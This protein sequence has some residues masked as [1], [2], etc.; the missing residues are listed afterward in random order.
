MR[1]ILFWIL[2][3]PVVTSCS[4]PL[5]P[6]FREIRNLSLRQLPLGTKQA[7]LAAE[8]VLYNPNSFGVEIKES[9]LDIFLADQY[10]GKA[11]QTLKIQVPAKKTFSLPVSLKILPGMLLKNGLKLLTDDQV[12]VWAKGTVYIGKAGIFKKLDI[13]Y[14]GLHSIP[15]S[16]FF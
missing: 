10:L 6:E 3:L 4:K 1:K 9:D 14:K 15:K 16:I 7:E 11:R 13:D 5:S 8:L 2:W 12:T